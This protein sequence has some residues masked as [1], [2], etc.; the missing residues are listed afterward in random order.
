MELFFNSKSKPDFIEPSFARIEGI[1]TTNTIT[2]EKDADLAEA[3]K[4]M[5][6]QGIS[7]LPVVELRDNA[8]QPIGIISKS[9]IVKALTKE[10]EEG[11]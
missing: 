2:I 7:G 4:I 9:D 11:R 5:I 1:M 3:A 6:K 8:E 10:Q